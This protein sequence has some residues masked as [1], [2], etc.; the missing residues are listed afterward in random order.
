MDMKQLIEELEI[1]PEEIRPIDIS[2][3]VEP[4]FLTDYQEGE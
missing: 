3:F 4:I 2:V 1:D